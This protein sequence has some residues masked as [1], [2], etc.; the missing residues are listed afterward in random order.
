LSGRRTLQNKSMPAYRFRPFTII[1]LPTI[2]RW[3]REDLDEPLMRQW[4]VE[5]GAQPLAWLRRGNGS[6]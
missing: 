4:I 6:Y 2:A 3:L 1:D 5:H